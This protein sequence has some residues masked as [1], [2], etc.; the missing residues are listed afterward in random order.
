MAGFDGRSYGTLFSSWVD[1]T[2]DHQ[3]ASLMG[4]TAQADTLATECLASFGAR[5]VAE[6]APIDDVAAL[7]THLLTGPAGLPVERA[8]LLCGAFLGACAARL[9]Q[10][11]SERRQRHD[12]T[13]PLQAAMLNL[14]LLMIDH[15]SN[16]ALHDELMAVKTS[17][18]TVASLLSKRSATCAGTFKLD[19]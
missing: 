7:L 1:A 2:N 3:L 8:N 19:T 14:E 4:T 10:L 6:A 16:T 9:A 12:V 17:L 15:Q 18:D 13:S 5:A 11:D